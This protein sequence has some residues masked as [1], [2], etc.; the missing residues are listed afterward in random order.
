M[1]IFGDDVGEPY[2]QDDLDK[3]YNRRKEK[4][5]PPFCGRSGLGPEGA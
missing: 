1:E 2:P 5:I 3:E 4:R